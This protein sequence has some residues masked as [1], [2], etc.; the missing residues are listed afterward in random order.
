MKFALVAFF[1]ALLCLNLTVFGTS[2]DTI[3]ADNPL[4]EYT[5]RIDF[6]NPLAPKFSYSGVSVRASFQGTSVSARL[7]DVG[8]Q[9]YYNVILDGVVA[10][11]IQTAAGLNTYAL[12]SA[13]KDTV[14]E[15]E[16]FRLT[17]VGFGK[18]QFNGLILD[19]GKTLVELSQKRNALVEYI[20]N[21]I[22]CGY[23]NEG[24]LGGT[25]G[26]TTE[27]HYLT[28]AAIT[29][30][31]FNA[32]HMA[33]CVSGIGVYRNYNGPFE[34]NVNCMSNYYQ[35][36]FF[37]DSTPL[38]GF[39]QTP[40]LVCIDLGTNDFS[41]NGGDSAKYVTAY[42]KLIDS[43]QV[44]N[45]KAN[46]LCLLGPMLGGSDLTKV[47]SC[48]N[49]IVTSANVKNNG[50]VYFFEMSQQTGSLGYAIDYHP[51]VAQHLK[52]ANELIACINATHLLTPV[53]VSETGTAEAGLDKNAL[54]LESAPNPFN[55]VTT[56]RFSLGT[57]GKVSMRIYDIN[58][59]FI[60]N[61]I[62]A[63]LTTGSHSVNWNATDSRNRTVSAG[64]YICRIQA[65]NQVQ[66]HRLMLIH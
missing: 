38:Y 3:P 52:N 19:S 59:R 15:I 54:A 36:I 8:I 61:L 22:T 50:N 30:R 28:Y 29:S 9:N 1:F 62:D 10:K 12:A 57:V 37:T 16:L 40:D 39:S 35:R 6:T 2:Y 20:G 53:T 17:E 26:P 4:I 56:L 27:N 47:R 48:L 66:T 23:G 60:K 45:N 11:R 51:T 65:G 34:G 32:R 58:G 31:N 13:L 7:N 33:V 21:S 43:I 63:D 46:I 44:K 42:L 5:G 18:T 49:R 55:P 14:H 25:F 41:T 24:V 64:M